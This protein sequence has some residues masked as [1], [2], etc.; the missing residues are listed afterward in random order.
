MQWIEDGYGRIGKLD[1]QTN[2]VQWTY[3][4][5]RTPKEYAKIDCSASA[6]RRWEVQRLEMWD[7][8]VMLEP[9]SHSVLASLGV[10]R[11]TMR[12]E[13]LHCD[14]GVPT[15]CLAAVMWNAERGSEL[16]PYAR[17]LLRNSFRR[18]LKR[19]AAGGSARPLELQP[20]VVDNR[21]AAQP[22]SAGLIAREELLSLGLSDDELSILLLRFDSGESFDNIARALG[23]NSRST[24]LH[25]LKKILD[26]CRRSR[27]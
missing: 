12:H 14:V 23:L 20:N 24:P 18:A 17:R 26:K 2:Q 19:G 8:A 13:E 27:A 9:L 5:T 10:P 6:E 22:P 1:E 3:G 25:H 7:D 4:S 16:R 21:A 15:L 11:H